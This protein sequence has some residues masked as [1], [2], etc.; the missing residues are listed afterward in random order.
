MSRGRGASLWLVVALI[1]ML[2]VIRRFFS[3]LRP[4]D[5]TLC[6]LEVIFI[7]VILWLEVPERFH[8]RK[9]RKGLKVVQR[10]MLDGHNLRTSVS[11]ATDDKTAPE[12]IQSVDKWIDT[13][14]SALSDTS[15]QAA[16]AFMHRS[17]LKPDIYYGGVTNRVD[18]SKQFQE[19]LIRLSNLLNIMEKADVYF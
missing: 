1:A 4:A 11:E 8:K 2:D 12:W 19:L 6:V 13:S 15:L 3:D 9:V 14:H 17:P 18:V 7:A 16:L 10:I 5:W